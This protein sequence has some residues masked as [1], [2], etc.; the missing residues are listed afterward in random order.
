MGGC[1]WNRY[2][3]VQRTGTV[4]APR[5]RLRV[6]QGDSKHPEAYPNAPE[7]VAIEWDVRPQSAEVRCSHAA[8]YAAVEGHGEMLKL[9]P[10]GVSGAVQGLANLYFATCHGEYGNDAELAARYG[11]DLR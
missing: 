3:D 4:N 6:T 7:G 2:D 8:P 11:Y 9:N 1:A 10:R 5:Y